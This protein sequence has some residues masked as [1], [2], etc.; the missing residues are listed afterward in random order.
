MLKL[1]SLAANFMREGRPVEWVEIRR[2]VDRTK[3]PYAE[4]T[5]ALA[6]FVA[7]RAGGLDPTFL[8]YMAAFHN[9]C[10]NPSVRGRLPPALYKALADFPHHFLAIAI[11]E[12]AYLC[13]VEHVVNRQCGW[14]KAAE[15]S[16]LSKPGSAA[17]KHASEAEDLLNSVRQAWAHT[18]LGPDLHV[19]NQVVKLFVLLDVAVAKVVLARPPTPASAARP[20]DEPDCFARVPQYFV[21]LAKTTLPDAKLDPI[22]ELPGRFADTV[23]AASA[24]A[25]AA[26]AVV[27]KAALE[28]YTVSSSGQ[29]MHGLALLR[30]KG[31]DKGSVVQEAASD[32]HFRITDVSEAAAEAGEHPRA[33]TVQ[34]VG[35][36]LAKGEEKNVGVLSFLETF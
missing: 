23:A 8:K 22:L 2:I 29:M 26:K 32:K 34:L 20:L 27:P 16:A 25:V 3:P 9:L 19:D 18:G 7:T 21:S 33:A 24:K 10:C 31:L 6:A 4:Y 35:L 12:T 28:L 5:D 13:P 14:I 30:Q 11:W 36:G 1:H 17:A 15:V